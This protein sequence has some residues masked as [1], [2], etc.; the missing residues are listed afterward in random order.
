MKYILL[1]VFLFSSILLTAQ[2]E[3]YGSFSDHRFKV[4][5]YIYIGNDT[6][7][8][9]STEAYPLEKSNIKI[10]ESSFSIDDGGMGFKSEKVNSKASVV[11]EAMGYSINGPYG[12]KWNVLKAKIDEESVIGVFHARQKMQPVLNYT[13]FST[14]KINNEELSNFLLSYLAIERENIKDYHVIEI[15]KYEIQDN[16]AVKVF[17]KKVMGR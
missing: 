3:F 9:S 11:N 15:G 8:I 5:D 4:D 1:F 17:V 16:A 7:V 13:V 6:L 14:H 2:D 12:D 10:S